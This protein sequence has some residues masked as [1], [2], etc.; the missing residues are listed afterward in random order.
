MDKKAEVLAEVR[1]H[2]DFIPVDHVTY[3]YE[4]FAGPMSEDVTRE[5]FRAREAVAVVVFDKALGKLALI[6]QFRI[7]T[8]LRGNGW[9][10]EL[11]AGMMDPGET[12]LEAALRETAEETGYDVADADYV[13]AFFTAPGGTTELVHLFHVEAEGRARVADGLEDEDIE[14]VFLTPEEARAM[15]WS[16]EIAD[17]KTIIGLSWWLTA[18]PGAQAR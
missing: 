18:G 4:T 12:P 2:D 16:G 13:T 5:V 9:L 15:L 7:H 1:V 17:A 11:A 3:R 14:T 6:R 8:H 10:L